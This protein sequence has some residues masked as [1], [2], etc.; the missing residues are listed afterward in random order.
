M[1]NPISNFPLFPLRG[2]L[3]IYF[4]CYADQVTVNLCSSLSFS[5]LNRLLSDLMV[6]HNRYPYHHF[7][8][9]SEISGGGICWLGLLL[10][11]KNGRNKKIE[12]WL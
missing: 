4:H 11:K 8:L 2:F 9:N 3:C 12:R 7:C 1:N 6:N 5:F 10:G